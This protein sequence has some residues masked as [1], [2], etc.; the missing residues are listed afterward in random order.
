MVSEYL[1]IIVLIFTKVKNMLGRISD[2]PF[3]LI[4]A[5][6]QNK[7]ISQHKLNHLSMLFI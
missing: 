3:V 2:L 1:K 6:A 5:R 4:S 7:I